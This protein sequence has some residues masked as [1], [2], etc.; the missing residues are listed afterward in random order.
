MTDTSGGCP[1]A[2]I[3]DVDGD[4]RSVVVWGDPNDAKLAANIGRAISAAILEAGAEI[5][6][7]EPTT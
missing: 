4:V 1:I 3:V 2:V 5:A 7:R 6:D